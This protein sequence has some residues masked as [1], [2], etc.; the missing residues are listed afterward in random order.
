MGSITSEEFVNKKDIYVIKSNSEK[1]NPYFLLAIINSSLVSFLKTK[2]STNATKDD[3]SQ[4]TLNDLREIPIKLV[5]EDLQLNFSDK[6]KS[7]LSWKNALQH[8]KDKFINRV[9]T[10]F[11]LEKISTNLD[12]FYD[13]DFKTFVSELKKQKVILSLSQQ[14]EWEEYLNSYKSE[15]NQL[16]SEIEKTDHEIDRMV[17]DLYGLTEE[18]IKIVEESV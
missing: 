15:I 16:Q 6:V 9:K 11:E 1:V 8:K 5:S 17:Y 10:S 18:E 3:F 7:I 2:G 13:S 14:D 4:L 12:T